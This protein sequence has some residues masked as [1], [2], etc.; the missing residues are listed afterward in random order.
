MLSVENILCENILYPM[1]NILQCKNY[2]LILGWKKK[3]YVGNAILY[4]YNMIKSKGE[5][6]KNS[7]W[8]ERCIIDRRRDTE[9]TSL[10]VFHSSDCSN[11]WSWAHSK[12]GDKSFFRVFPFG[13][14]AQGLEL[15]FA[16]FQAI[17]RDRVWKWNS[18]PRLD[19]TLSS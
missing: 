6:K 15:Y 13:E 11:R 8:L 12:T 3:H 7:F 10:P 19:E 17:N 2:Q 9:R 5:K 14:G 1:H 4:Y 18:Q 16:A